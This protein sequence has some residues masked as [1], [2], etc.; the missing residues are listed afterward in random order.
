MTSTELKI[1]RISPSDVEQ[2]QSTALLLDVRTP[3]E[4]EESHIP[5]SVLHPLGNLNPVEVEILAAGK[6]QCVVICQSGKRAAQAADKLK[7]SSLPDLKCHGRRSGGMGGGGIAVETGAKDD[8]VGTSGAYC[9]WRLC[10]HWRV[11]WIFCEPAVDCSF[12]LCRS[13]ADFCGHHGHVRDGH[14]AGAHAVE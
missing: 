8:V 12:R 13:G 1:N 9:C 5:G 10:P 3:A 2:N 4:F 11:A 7:M 6:T 14:G